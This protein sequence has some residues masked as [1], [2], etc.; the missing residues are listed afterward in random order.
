M[1]KIAYWGGMVLLG[2]AIGYFSADFA[3]RGVGL[4][5]QI[6]VGP[7]NTNLANGSKDADMYTRARVAR[8]GLLALDKKETIYYTAGTDDAGEKLSG[9]CTYVVEGKDLAARWWSVTAYGPD[10]YLIPND[11]GIYSFAKTTVK[12]EADG[13]YIVRVSPD[14]QEGN[15]VPVKAG[16]SF[17]LTARF[18]NPE[19][20]VYAAPAAAE[21]PHITKES[22]K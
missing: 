16:E 11:A 2:I 17:D 8:Y 14:R 10:S 3:I 5:G 12:R 6:K 1:K 21:L 9:S 19:A 15:W 13:H 20:S 4:G 7:W 18:Y 22:C